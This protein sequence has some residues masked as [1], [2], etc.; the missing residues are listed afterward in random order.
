MIH[1]FGSVHKGTPIS[2][3]LHNFVISYPN[4][5]ILNR[6]DI[7]IGKPSVSFNFKRS[8][9]PF[10]VILSIDPLYKGIL[11]PGIGL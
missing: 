6:F 7:L 8:Y 5:K 3:N 4:C 2:P 9:D 10:D 1:Y 11:N